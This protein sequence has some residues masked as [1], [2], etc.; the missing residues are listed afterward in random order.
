MRQFCC[1]N[2]S[3]ISVTKLVMNFIP[4][5]KSFQDL[6]CFLNRGFRYLNGLKSSLQRWIFLNVLSVFIKSS[7]P[8]TLSHKNIRY[9]NLNLTSCSKFPYNKS[10]TYPIIIQ[11]YTMVK[12]TNEI[13]DTQRHKLLLY[14]I[15][16]PA[17]LL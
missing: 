3:I 16:L 8:N 9:I 12:N 15:N 6:Y 2:Y 4:L 11:Q 10:T 1:S 14:I 17:I 13:N 7:S 5:S